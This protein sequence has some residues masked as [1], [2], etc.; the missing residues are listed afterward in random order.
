MTVEMVAPKQSKFKRLHF[1]LLLILSF[2]V[3][4]L[5]FVV[6]S[7]FRWSNPLD[8]LAN[9]IF[10]VM[11]YGIVWGI[12]LLPWSLFIYG[13]YRWRKWRRFRTAWVLAPSVL[14]FVLSIVS[15]VMNPP[16]PERRFLSFAK[17][18]LPEKCQNLHYNFSGGGLADYGDTYYFETTPEDVDKLVA[19][20]QLSKDEVF[21]VMEFSNS[22]ISPLPDW[23]DYKTWGNPVQYKRYDDG[24]FY[25]LI[26][27]ESKTRV[28]VLVGCI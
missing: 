13:L 1:G 18:K 23:P 28:Y 6:D 15:L 20:M 7:V 3:F 11:V 21:G 5:G 4:N 25:Y 16:D 26:T 27:D 19:T 24:W 14:I 22:P 8:G 2:A 12:Y 17:T 10:H 9:G